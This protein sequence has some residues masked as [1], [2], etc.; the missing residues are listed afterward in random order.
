MPPCVWAGRSKVI[1][2]TVGRSSDR[3]M[4]AMPAQLSEGAECPANRRGRPDNEKSTWHL[5]ISSPISD[6]RMRRHNGRGAIEIGFTDQRI[7]PWAGLYHGRISMGGFRQVLE[8]AL[9]LAQQ[10]EQIACA[11]LA[12]GYL[13]GIFSGALSWPTAQVRIDPLLP[14][15][16][17]SKR[18]GSQSSYLPL[19]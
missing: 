14:E 5:T 17:G 18:L 6:Q 8:Q 1:N 16:L 7:S 2:F 15:M 11:D 19:L 12:P 3:T 4:E 10:P 13:A 9:P